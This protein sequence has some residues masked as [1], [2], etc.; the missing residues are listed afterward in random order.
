M[1]SELQ[2]NEG[3]VCKMWCNVESL[4]VPIVRSTLCDGCLARS[5][6][7]CYRARKPT[8]S[9]STILTPKLTNLGQFSNCLVF[10]YQAYGGV[11]S[12]IEATA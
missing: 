1:L 9:L 4:L 6:G 8:R 3:R 5:L 7:G 2:A 10:G 11:I 12:S